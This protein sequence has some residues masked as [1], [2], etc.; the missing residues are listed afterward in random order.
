VEDVPFHHAVPVLT[1]WDIGNICDDTPI[2]QIEDFEY[3]RD[4]ETRTGTMAYTITSVFRDA[5]PSPGSAERY[6]VK[7]L[8]FNS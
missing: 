8:G 6:K 5:Y 7:F 3:V 1:G 2:K 4:P